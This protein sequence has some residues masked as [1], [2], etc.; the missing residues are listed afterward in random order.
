MANFNTHLF[1]ASATSSAAALLTVNQQLI[2]WADAPW[3][4]FMGAIGGLLPDIDS[5]NTKQVRIV[6]V[7]LALLSTFSVLSGESLLQDIVSILPGQD[8]ICHI[9]S[10]TLSSLL[11]TLAGKC[12]SLTLLMLALATFVSVRYVL[13]YIFKSLTVHRGV[14]HS[15][16]AA[17]F[18]VLLASNISF[19]LFQQTQSFA[20]LNGLFIGF[21]FMIHLLLDEIYSVDLSN[22]RVKRSFGTALKLYNYKNHYASLLMLI[23]TLAL[24]ITMPSATP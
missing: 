13:L 17:I 5:D 12:I 11:S 10:I 6:F 24:Y 14:F 7:L 9:A 21:G 18:F 15:L 8:A 16:L 3:L 20:W 19:H 2:H 22:A 4:V 23:C 1:I